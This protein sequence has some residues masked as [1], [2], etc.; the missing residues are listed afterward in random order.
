[1]TA[2]RLLPAA[3]LTF[4]LTTACATPHSSHTGADTTSWREP[5]S[6]TYTLVSRTQVL[7]GT[8]HLTV[9]NHRATSATPLPDHVPASQLPTIGALLT[10]L[11]TARHDNADTADIEYAPDGRPTRIVLDD[12]RNAID[13]EE[14][15]LIT[16]FRLP[17]A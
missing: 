9:R 3:A 5:P 1:M 17:P 12:D 2:T 16:N 10:R 15:Y 11:R 8:F 14:T 4:I 7:H 13:D 6:Y